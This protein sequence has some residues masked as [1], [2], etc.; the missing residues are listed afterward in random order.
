MPTRNTATTEVHTGHAG[1][2]EGANEAVFDIAT[3]YFPYEAGWLG[4]WVS[5]AEE[6]EALFQ[7]G[8]DELSGEEVVLGDRARIAVQLPGIDSASDGMLFVAP[9]NGSS[10]VAACVRISQRSWRLDSYGPVGWG[11]R[12]VR[13]DVSRAG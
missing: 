5:A 12:H 4:A 1:F 13:R 9:S 3:A 6:G 8:S 10:D 7:G 11:R 2:A